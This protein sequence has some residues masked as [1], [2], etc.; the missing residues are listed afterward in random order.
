ML[1]KKIIITA[2]LKQAV[3]IIFIITEQEE[4]IKAARI[5]LMKISIKVEKESSG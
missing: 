4:E 5:N 2:I 3:K 1:L